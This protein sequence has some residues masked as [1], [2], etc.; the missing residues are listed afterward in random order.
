MLDDAYLWTGAGSVETSIL[1]GDNEVL[2]TTGGL[3][4]GECQVK[5]ASQHALAFKSW[6]CRLHV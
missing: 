3:I 5:V 2:E 4:C 6:E 1:D